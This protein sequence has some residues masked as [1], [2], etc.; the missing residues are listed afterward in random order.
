MPCPEMCVTSTLWEVLAPC[1]NEVVLLDDPPDVLQLNLG[2]A[3]ISGKFNLGFE[4]NFASPLAVCTWTSSAAPHEKRKRNDIP[5]FEGR[6]G[7]SPLDT[8]S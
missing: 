7:S 2:E 4:Q 8:Q 5:I 3:L 6:L 1:C